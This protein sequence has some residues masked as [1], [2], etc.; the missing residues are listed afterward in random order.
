MSGATVIVI[1][2]DWVVVLFGQD[3]NKLAMVN[4]WIRAVELGT[5]QD[6]VHCPVH[7]TQRV[8]GPG[9]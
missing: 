9:Q 7:N 1:Q 4:F 3:K 5:S 8:Q 6:V 2:K